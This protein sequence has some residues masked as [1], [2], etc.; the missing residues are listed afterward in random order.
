MGFDSRREKEIVLFSMAF[1][2]AL[3]LTRPSIRWIQRALRSGVKRPG[4]EELITHLY[5]VH[6]VIPPLPHTSAW[7][8]AS[9]NVIER[10]RNGFCVACRYG[11]S[12]VLRDRCFPNKESA[13]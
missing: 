13:P 7:C 8:S 3:R 1:R 5:H 4:C 12:E 6:G 10:D 2:P 9:Y 11:I